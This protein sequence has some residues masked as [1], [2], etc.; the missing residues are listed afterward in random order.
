[1][2]ARAD[3]NYAC[4]RRPKLYAHTQT[5]SY[6]YAQTKLYAHSQTKII[7]NYMRTRRPKIYANAKSKIMRTLT[8]IICVRPDE[9][10]CTCAYQ[11][12]M[13]MRISFQSAHLM[14]SA[15]FDSVS[16]PHRKS[17][18]EIQIDVEFCHCC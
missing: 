15:H 14:Q 2:S 18:D 16:V 4:T 7:Q 6:A 17:D 3:Q 9:I 1:M 11:N 8:K 5:Q 12:Y 10:V 13:R